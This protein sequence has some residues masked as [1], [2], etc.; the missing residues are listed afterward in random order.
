MCE[1]FFM[2]LKICK[3]FKNVSGSPVPTGEFST[4]N[5]HFIFYLSKVHRDKFQSGECTFLFRM[6]DM[7]VIA[8]KISIIDWSAPYMKYFL[9]IFTSYIYLI[10]T[11]WIIL[12]CKHVLR[13]YMYKYFYMM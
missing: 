4:I 1:N 9:D 3:N 2:G 8:A 13:I 10:R 11:V 5:F 12:R 7:N 6:R